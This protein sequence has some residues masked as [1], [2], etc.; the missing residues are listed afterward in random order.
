MALKIGYACCGTTAFPNA[1][2]RCARLGIPST[3]LR[4]PGST[5]HPQCSKWLV[6]SCF[7]RLGRS[8][9]LPD[10]LLE[11]ATMKILSLRCGA[12]TS[13]APQTPHPVRYPSEAKSSRILAKN[14]PRSLVSS[15]GTFSKTHHL[16]LNSL[17]IRTHSSHKSRSSP[18]ALRFPA[19]LWG[20]HDYGNPPVIRPMDSFF[21]PFLGIGLFRLCH[22]WWCR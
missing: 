7:S 8:F 19:T 22:S 16:G 17:V 4:I 20:W 13:T 6:R 2:S 3:T 11:W 5:L 10:G 9:P 14:D 21:P 15:P 12:P 1:L 18:D